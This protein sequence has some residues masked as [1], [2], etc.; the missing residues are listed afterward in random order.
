MIL[1]MRFKLR[2]TQGLALLIV[3]ACMWE[4][5]GQQSSSGAAAEAQSHWLLGIVDA[6]V[7]NA[8]QQFAARKLE[9]NQIAVTL[10]DLRDRTNPVRASFR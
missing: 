2:T 8:L 3:S 5:S 7:R 9:S 1:A 4:A 10:V 6:A